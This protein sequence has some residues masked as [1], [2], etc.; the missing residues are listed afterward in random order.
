MYSN[1]ILANKHRLN[2]RQ[3][4]FQKCIIAGNWLMLCSFIIALICIL[5]TFQFDQYFSIFVQ[6]GAHILTIV[7][8]GVLKIGYVLRC[9]GF[10][11]LGFK[12][13]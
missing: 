3:L 13:F 2:N 12:R 9:I 4:N 6:V 11:G 10:D 8:A 5:V 7:F 1:F